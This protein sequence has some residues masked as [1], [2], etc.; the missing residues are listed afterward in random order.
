MAATERKRASD[1]LGR[2]FGSADRQAVLEAALGP[3]RVLA[4]LDLEPGALADGLVEDLA[5]VADV[6]DDAVGP[7]VGQAEGLAVLAFRSEKTLDLRIVRALH[8]V[9]IRLGDTEL[10]GIQHGRMGPADDVAPL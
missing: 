5:V 8:L 2:P 10:L 4:A 3:E 7:I 6:L 1:H 9:D